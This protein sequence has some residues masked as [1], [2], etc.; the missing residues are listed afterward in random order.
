MTRSAGP[1]IGCRL[2]VRSVICC[3][4]MRGGAFAEADGIDRD[5]GQR[6]RDM[7]GLAGVV[8]ADDGDVAADDEAVPRGGQHRADGDDVVVAD[9][10][11]RPVGEREHGAHRAEA[12]IARRHALEVERR[13]DRAAGRVHRIERS[14]R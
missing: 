9:H 7:A 12:A 4:S 5:G 8:E 13:V 2:G 11:G 10:G 6:R 14:R 1:M 3:S